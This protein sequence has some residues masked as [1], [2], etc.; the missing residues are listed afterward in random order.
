M[1]DIISAVGNTILPMLGGFAQNAHERAAWEAEM[2]KRQLEIE[3][4][5]ARARQAAIQLAAQQAQEAEKS[6]RLLVIAGSVLALVVGAVF[7]L[8]Q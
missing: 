4:E 1:L 3:A 2:R 5:E 7:L 6:K 8:R